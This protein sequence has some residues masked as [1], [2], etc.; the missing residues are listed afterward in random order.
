M[1]RRPGWGNRVQA[2]RLAARQGLRW[3]GEGFRIFFAAPVAQLLIDLAFLLAVMLLLAVPVVG[4][5]IAWVLFPALLVGPQGAARAASRRAAPTA[6]FLLSGFRE[7][8]PRQLQLGGVYLAAMIAVLAATV[9]ADGGQF[10]RAMAG[11]VKLDPSDLRNP[12]L[13][14]AMLI[15]AGLQTAALSALW[16]APL[17]VA[18]HGLAVPKAVFFSAAAVLINW[19]A[20]FA[21]AIALAAVFALLLFVALNLAVLLTGAGA[22]VPVNAVL[23]AVLWSS[24]PVGFASSYLSYRDVFGVPAQPDPPAA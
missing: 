24:L 13:L 4:M 21:Y 20:F 7:H 8:F 6:E 9:P 17:L 16:F 19:R 2:N 10:A 5:A 15:G 12:A 11:Q 23:F 3:V 14:E 22:A 18:W 1:P